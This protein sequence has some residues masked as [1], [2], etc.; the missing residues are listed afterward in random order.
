[1]QNCGNFRPAA[2][3]GQF[4]PLGRKCADPNHELGLENVDEP[5]QVSVAVQGSRSSQT[6]VVNE[7]VHPPTPSHT[8]LVQGSPSSH[9]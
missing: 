5:S 9:E 8:P 4:G 6:T 2:S 1:M 3:Q 7:T